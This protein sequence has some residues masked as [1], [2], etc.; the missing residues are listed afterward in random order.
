M[1]WANDGPNSDISI[2]SFSELTMHAQLKKSDCY[3][4]YVYD[5]RK[6]MVMMV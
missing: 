5:G 1:S 2:I 6:V 3:T 4:R